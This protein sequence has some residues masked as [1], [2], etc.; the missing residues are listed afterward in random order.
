MK[1]IRTVILSLFYLLVF[2]VIA[3]CDSD[4]D[5]EPG[6]T[7]CPTED[8]LLKGMEDNKLYIVRSADELSAHVVDVSQ[9]A[10]IDYTKNSLL[11]VRGGTRQGI[12]EIDGRFTEIFN[13][14]VDY[15]F[16]IDIVL[17]MTD[18]MDEWQMIVA[19]PVLADDADVELN[20][21]VEVPH[22]I[23]IISPSEKISLK[24]MENDKLY[25]VRSVDE[26]FNYVTNIDQ[27]ADVN[28]THRSLLL[29]KGGTRQ[30][31][32]QI[33]ARYKTDFTDYN[34]IF[35]VD[36]ELNDADVAEEWQMVVEVPILRDDASFELNINVN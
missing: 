25:I 29:V 7:V 33:D 31:I 6:F 24:N 16:D 23:R 2:S 14:S 1:E 21:F 27:L 20:I 36:I 30:G 3:G 26:L 10:K 35:D 15:I 4:S 13:G 11:L 32:Q 34:C 12:Q 19:V 17:N 5:T 28:Y 18:A 9:V 22:D 8:V